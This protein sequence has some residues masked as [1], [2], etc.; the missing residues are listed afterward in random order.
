[1]TWSARDRDEAGTL[2]ALRAR[3]GHLP[4]TPC[5]IQARKTLGFAER[6]LAAGRKSSAL[7]AYRH[8]QTWLEAD[9]RGLSR[10]DEAEAA[11]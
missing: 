10:Q 8:A 11:A 1:M 7:R 4:E 9:A 2:A 6:E 3:L 5:T